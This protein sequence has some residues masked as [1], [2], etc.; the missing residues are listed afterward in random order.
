MTLREALK[1]CDQE[2]V[3]RL[4]VDKDKD[5]I[6]E[7]DKITLDKAREAYTKVIAELLSKPETVAAD[8]PW[9]IREETDWFDGHKYISVGFVN[10]NYVK[11]AEGLVAWGGDGKTPVPDGMYD[12]NDD[13]YNQYFAAG[14]SPWSETIDTPI[15]NENNYPLNVM[16]AEMLWEITFYGWT[17]KKQ[18]EFVAEIKNRLHDAIEGEE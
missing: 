17:E 11:P 12:C 15:I 4:I 5:Y 14:F 13:K 6:V 18:E 1:S 3:F 8:M 10:P 9:V 2:E 7:S 16:V